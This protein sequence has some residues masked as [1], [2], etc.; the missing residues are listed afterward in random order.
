MP[1]RDSQSTPSTPR[2]SS[3]G[4]RSKRRSPT[5]P[6]ESSSPASQPNFDSTDPYKILGV[7]RD[8]TIQQIKISYRKLALA[9]HPDRQTT[10]A[11]K[12]A[13]HKNFASIGGAYEILGDEGRRRE[14]DEGL[15]RQ[16]QQQQ[17]KG[18]GRGI[19]DDD[20]GGNFGHDPFSM[21]NDHPFFSSSFG[22][23]SGRRSSRSGVRFK[24]PFELFEQ[25]F[26]EEMGHHG[27]QHNNSRS[28]SGSS[29]PFSDPFFSSGDPF[30]DPFFSSQGSLF[31]RGGM[32]QMMS[33]HGNLMNSMMSQMQSGSM[34]GGFDEQQQQQLMRSGGNGGG[35]SSYNFMSSSSSS[36]NRGGVQSVSTST[37]TSIVNGVRKTIKTKTYFW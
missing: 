26:A 16:Q 18:R 28:S 25:F 37:R 27:R 19:F 30:S 23:G 15:R 11:D 14:H 24:D 29:N 32:S 4:H 22:G 20:I 5:D 17:R 2:T 31:G 36:S 6:D 33:G 1:K 34:F 35:S 9:H 8:A 21:F 12:E 13:A 10:E 7:P 3:S